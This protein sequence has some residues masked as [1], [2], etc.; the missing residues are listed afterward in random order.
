MRYAWLVPVLI[1]AVALGFLIYTLANLSRLGITLLH[2][3]VLVEF[4][5][6][7]V[8]LAIG[9]YIKSGC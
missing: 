3:R 2:P 4:G 1:S 8:F 9:L 7:I 6:F 5:I